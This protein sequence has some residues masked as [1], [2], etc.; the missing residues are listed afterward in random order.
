MGS[1]RRSM[2]RGCSGIGRYMGRSGGRGDL[3]I[4]GIV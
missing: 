1:G 2:R 4:S 3:A